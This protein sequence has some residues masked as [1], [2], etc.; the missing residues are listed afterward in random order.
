MM[1]HLKIESTIHYARADKSVIGRDMML[2]Q[3]K[4]VLGE[5]G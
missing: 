2:L 4:M 3:E 5:N 1:G